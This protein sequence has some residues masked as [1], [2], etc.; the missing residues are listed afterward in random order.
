[1][2]RPAQDIKQGDALCRFS[3]SKDIRTVLRSQRAQTVAASNDGLE[4]WIILPLQEK[5]E[6]VNGEYPG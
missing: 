3:W 5:S 2:S 4:L 1:M 6:T